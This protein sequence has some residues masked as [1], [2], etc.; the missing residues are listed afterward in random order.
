MTPTSGAAAQRLLARLQLAFEPLPTRRSRRAAHPGRPTG[1][2]RCGHGAPRRRAVG[3]A[4]ARAA[5]APGAAGGAGRHLGLD[6]PLFAHAA[7]LRAPLG[8]ADARVE[9]FVFGTRL[10]RTTRLLKS[11]DPDLAVRQ[12]VRAVETGP[13][14]PASPSLHEFNQ[15]WARRV[16]PASATVLLVTDGLEHGDTT[17]L[18]ER[19]GA[20]AQELPRLIWLNPLLRFERLRAARRRRARDAAARRPHSCR[21]NLASLEDLVQVLAAPA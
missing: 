21:H 4:L 7:A 18:A 2:P 20:P 10:T 11:R 5:H 8:H 15:R 17:P 13:A 9:S 12:V 14:A 1:A 19:D 16:L 3:P 6:E